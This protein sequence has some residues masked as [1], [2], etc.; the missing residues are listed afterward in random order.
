MYEE[1][2][3]MGEME[4]GG[5]RASPNELTRIFNLMREIQDHIVTADNLPNRTI[6]QDLE[7][8]DALRPT[9]GYTVELTS[10]SVLNMAMV[11]G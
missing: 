10:N 3:K 4:E 2:E 6:H 11:T 8:S 1:D 5:R 9:I 7:T